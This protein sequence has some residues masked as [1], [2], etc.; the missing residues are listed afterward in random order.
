MKTCMKISCLVYILLFVCT[1]SNFVVM[2]CE[3]VSNGNMMVEDSNMHIQVMDDSD[4]EEGFMMVESVVGIVGTLLG[5]FLGWALSNLSSNSYK[6]DLYFVCS[7]DAQ[8]PC[9]I[10]YC[11][12]N[13]PII[14]RKVE[15]T[16]NQGELL[17]VKKFI[18]EDVELGSSDVVSISPGSCEKIEFTI[19]ELVY[20]D[21]HFTNLSDGDQKQKLKL[22]MT[23][24]RG[25]R[26]TI[27][28]KCTLEEYAIVVEKLQEWVDAGLNDR[29]EK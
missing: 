2:A 28:T 5:T 10:V 7:I 16:I 11:R 21:G 29:G 3:A 22:C 12:G 20:G 19:D 17:G 18:N 24:L 27:M 8:P 9:L 25:K 6:A 14:P 23:D 13:K 4:Y 1:G 26:Y 15:I